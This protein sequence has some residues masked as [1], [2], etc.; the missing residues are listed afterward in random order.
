ML[1][2]FGKDV[3]DDLESRE[4]TT[5]KWTAEEL[6]EIKKY[7][8]DKI[9]SIERGERPPELPDYSGMAVLDMFNDIPAPGQVSEDAS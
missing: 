8:A 9:K 5:K 3:V 4:F 6:K 2:K 7:Y 1:R